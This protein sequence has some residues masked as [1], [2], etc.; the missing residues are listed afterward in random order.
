MGLLYSV[1]GFPVFKLH[2][3]FN[4][5]RKNSPFQAKTLFLART[6]EQSGAVVRY[7]VHGRNKQAD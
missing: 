3:R 2:F 6:Q 1:F 7:W 4:L 5:I